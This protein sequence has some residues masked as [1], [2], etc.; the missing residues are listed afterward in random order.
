MNIND[1]AGRGEKKKVEAMCLY[2]C[3]YFSLITQTTVGYGHHP[4]PTVISQTV[5]MVQLI[6]ILLLY[7]F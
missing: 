2:H 4:A 1:I 3:F 5:N 7:L 6:C